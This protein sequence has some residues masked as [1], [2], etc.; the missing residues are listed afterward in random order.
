M[1]DLIWRSIV[2]YISSL[3][4]T[5]IHEIEAITRRSIRI[6]VLLNRIILAKSICLFEN[7]N[8]F[9]GNAKLKWEEDS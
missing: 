5:L 4:Q 7:I 1:V 2:T 6:V 8:T 3:I 9:K